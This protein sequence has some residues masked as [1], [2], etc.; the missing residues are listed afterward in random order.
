[1]N[2]VEVDDDNTFYSIF[3]VPRTESITIWLTVAMSSSNL[4]CMLLI[5]SYIGI[6][7]TAQTD[8]NDL[9]VLKSLKKQWK[10]TP[11]NWDGIDPC[12]EKWDGIFCKGSRV[13]TILLSRA[14]LIGSLPQV[15]LSL[16]EL[17]KLD[18]SDN[19]KLTGSLPLNIGSLKN[20]EI[21]ILSGCSFS[22]NIPESIGSMLQLKRLFLNSNNFNGSIPHSIGNL[23]KLLWLDLTNNQLNGKLPISNKTTPGLDQLHEAE[24][25]HFGQNKLSGEIPRELFHIDMKL[26]HLIFN[27]NRLTGSIPDTLEHVLSLEVIR[28]DRNELSGLVPQNLSRLAKVG[29]LNLANNSLIG[30]VPDLS[31]MHS[32]AYVDLSNNSFDESE[33]PLWC[34][35][36]PKIT[37]LKMENTSLIG[38]IPAALLNQSDLQT[39]LLRN[40]KLNGTVNLETGYGSK[41]RFIDL[42]NTF[43]DEID[44]GEY[45]YRIL[46][47]GETVCRKGETQ[48]NCNDDLPIDFFEYIPQ[49]QCVSLSCFENQRKKACKRPYLGRLIFL[50]YNFSDLHT[51]SYYNFNNTL[52][53]TIGSPHI[54]EICLVRSRIDPSYDYLVLEI[55]ILPPEGEHFNQSLISFIGNILQEH[56]FNVQLPYKHTPVCND[57]D[58]CK[59]RKL[60]YRLI[61]STSI[62]I[63][64]LVLI[65][66][67]VGAYA[68]RQ[69]KIAIRAIKLNNPFATW[70]KGDLPQLKGV[71]VFTLE[72]IERC[73]NNFSHSS[74]I[75][76]GGYGKV[77]KGKLDNEQLVAIKRAKKDSLQSAHEFKT[78][79]ELLSR[80]HHRNIVSL[81]G[82]CYDKDEQ[83]LIYE[84]VPNNSL[85]A[86]LR[87][88][89]EVRLDWM[90]RLMVALGAARG[91][92]YLHELADPP[93]IHR[94]I[95]S[96]NILLDDYLNA[97]VGDFG[98]CKPV[99]NDTDYSTSQIKGTMGYLDPE[100]LSGR[101]L[102]EKS[103]VYSFGVVMLELITGRPPLEKNKG[104]IVQE[105]K[106][107]MNETGYI[108]NLVDPVIRSGNLICIEEF[109]ELALLCV[110]DSGYNRPSMSE[111]VKEI[112]SIIQTARKS[113][114]V[115][116]SSYDG[117]SEI[118]SGQSSS[119]ISAYDGS[120]RLLR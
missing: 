54:S 34:S 66:I 76:I 105:V 48:G 4:A 53:S 94:D 3:E 71:K 59:M 17:K 119:V 23:R 104:Y 29:E 63:F 31:E 50:S 68:Y 26:R 74:E 19:N 69:R 111:V 2:R 56:I 109:T 16:S 96:G 75:G 45:N 61:I 77:Y 79:I 93:I 113:L 37:T 112:E 84:Y 67:F 8:A 21:L 7:A 72:D 70:N 89:S 110:E 120:S 99:R 10:N 64:V 51:S 9:A 85:K 116:L 97:K 20:L 82:F 27:D 58:I 44:A 6:E 115:V 40:N 73:T 18:L 12:G 87:G 98:L 30:P 91:L 15:V 1:M 62:S 117:T 95:K 114:S 107:T 42:R 46:F 78:E 43:I 25:F 81:V 65:T 33:I 32:L 39:V 88:S 102:T 49:T 13:T 60:R 108:Y 55:A 86:S 41:L 101:Q 38:Q 36:L 118:D 28:L 5:F 83:M 11:S 14:K 106:V 92:A 103:D 100:Y 22:G 90:S 80:V 47:D 24:H 35:T 57:P 52:K